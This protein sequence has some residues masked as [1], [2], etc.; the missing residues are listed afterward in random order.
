[1]LIIV[2]SAMGRDSVADRRA[3]VHCS[4]S[5]A[6]MVYMRCR[7]LCIQDTHAMPL[8]VRSRYPCAH[9][10]KIPDAG[11]SYAPRVL[12]APCAPARRG[13]EVSSGKRCA[14]G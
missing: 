14:S 12:G 10:F 3:A 9:A 13:A 1:V 11:A 4:A 7:S 5:H 6:F 8:I 2:I